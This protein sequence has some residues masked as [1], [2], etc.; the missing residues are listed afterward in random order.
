MAL[1]HDK[2]AVADKLKCTKKKAAT[3]AHKEL[4]AET[5]DDNL[6][7]RHEG[8]SPDFQKLH[9]LS[10]QLEAENKCLKAKIQHCDKWDM[11][12]TVKTVLEPQNK[13]E[14]DIK[15]IHGH[16]NLN[17]KENDIEWSILWHTSH[18][19]LIM[20]GLNWDLMWS[21]QDINKIN[22][23]I[24]AAEGQCLKMWQFAN[25]WGTAGTMKCTCPNEDDEDEPGED[26]SN[27]HACLAKVCKAAVHQ[28]AAH[29]AA[30]HKAEAEATTN[31]KNNTDTP[32][33]DEE[34]EPKDLPEAV[35]KAIE[36]EEIVVP[37]TDKLLAKSY[38]GPS[39]PQS[40]MSLASTTHSTS[41]SKP[42]ALIYM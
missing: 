6:L 21:K 27:K 36:W 37:A 33:D 5:V 3:K 10:L 35:H 13:G 15:T 23:L 26:T 9:D 11:M 16:L 18:A 31:T 32:H 29:L 12:S 25:H 24:H 34:T 4:C 1:G 30:R 40:L 17:G 38:P 20:A 2:N 39:T 19:L 22:T 8:E 42:C 7:V 41:S 28:A 14:V